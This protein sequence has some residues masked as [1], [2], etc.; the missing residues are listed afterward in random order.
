MSAQI[1]PVIPCNN[2]SFVAQLRPAL[3]KF[4]Q[5]R[6]ANASEAEDLAQDVI[7][8]VLAHSRWSSQDEAKGYI[9]RTAANRWHDRRRR[10]LSHGKEV[11][12]NDEVARG[13][14]EENS[15]E[16]VFV[17][18]EELRRVAAALQELN[19]RTR[20]VFVLHRLERLKQAEIA[21]MLGISI[22]SVEKHMLKALAHLARR[23]DRSDR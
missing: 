6:C 4:F 12:W 2:A 16:R 10:Q 7:V 19:E 23:I 21:E 22:S 9:F 15:P 20:D 3:V 1:A 17:I 8:R 13:L 5:R 14:D 18:K 11:D